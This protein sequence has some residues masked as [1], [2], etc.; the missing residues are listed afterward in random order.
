M[1]AH[2][3]RDQADQGKSAPEAEAHLQEQ[4]PENVSWIKIERTNLR[5]F[6]MLSVTLGFSPG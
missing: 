4:N 1:K 6:F 2:Q 5:S 3:S